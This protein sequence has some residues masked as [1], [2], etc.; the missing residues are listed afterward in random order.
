MSFSKT[1]TRYDIMFQLTGLYQKEV[2]G[3]V[4]R[5]RCSVQTVMMCDVRCFGDCKG[6]ARGRPAGSCWSE[7]K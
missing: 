7:R 6:K 5:N 1:K 3:T 4:D 2:K